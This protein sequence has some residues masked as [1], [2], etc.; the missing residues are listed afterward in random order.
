MLCLLKRKTTA[1]KVMATVTR[2]RNSIV[3]IT[4]SPIVIR[5][6]TESTCTIPAWCALGNGCDSNDGSC[7]SEGGAHQWVWEWLLGRK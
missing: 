4:G 2:R 1:T 5:L 6:L 3:S 7:I